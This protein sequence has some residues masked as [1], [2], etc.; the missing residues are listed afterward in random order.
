L[1]ATKSPTEFAAFI[2]HRRVRLGLNQR[3]LAEK[4]G[5]QPEFIGMMEKG[6]RMLDLDRVPD[7]AS[8]LD[9]TT[10]SLAKLAIM[11][12]YPRLG[13]M[14]FRNKNEFKTH[15]SPKENNLLDK[16][17]VLDSS[18]RHSV[19]DMVD[20]LY[21]QQMESAKRGRSA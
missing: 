9:V 15:S 16:L 5:Y 18:L 1:A 7:M 19:I 2:K 10:F 21:E 8:A 17:A 14:L 12:L 4:I 3:E 6:T 13:R 20:R 11:A